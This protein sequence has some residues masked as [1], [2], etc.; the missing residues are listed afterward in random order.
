MSIATRAVISAIVKRLAATNSRC[1]PAAAGD[2]LQHRHCGWRDR[3]SL[4]SVFDP[5]NFSAIWKAAVTLL[6]KQPVQA[7]AQL[8]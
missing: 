2:N 8:C 7:E 1:P 6:T 5:S 3:A 4:R